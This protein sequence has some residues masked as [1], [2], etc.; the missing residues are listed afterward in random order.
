[1][2]CENGMRPYCPYWQAI[3]WRLLPG[4]YEGF[5]PP[6][7]GRKGVLTANRLLQGSNEIEPGSPQGE[8]GLSGSQLL[9]SALECNSCVH[10]CPNKPSQ[11]RNAPSPYRSRCESRQILSSHLP[12]IHSSCFLT[13]PLSSSGNFA[14]NHLL[15]SFA[16]IHPVQW[17]LHCSVYMTLYL[18]HLLILLFP[19][20]YSS[21]TC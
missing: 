14:A 15:P 16:H 11:R 2:K 4:T 20:L 21:V 8:G 18:L 13:S 17:Q 9:C 12:V 3:F 19:S 6:V 1:M 10:I 5:L 7:A